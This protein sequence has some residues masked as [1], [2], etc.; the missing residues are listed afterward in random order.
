[1]RKRRKQTESNQPRTMRNGHASE[2][3]DRYRR[4]LKYRGGLRLSN[5][6]VLKWCP[7]KKKGCY[8]VVIVPVRRQSVVT[9]ANGDYLQ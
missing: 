1:M 3:L 9:N 7:E 2:S 8:I 4:A 5:S 6:G